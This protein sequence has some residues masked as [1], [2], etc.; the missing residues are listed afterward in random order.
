MRLTKLELH[1]F[2][3]FAD[4]TTLAFEAGVTAIVGP[5]GCGK[6][7]VSDAVRWVL[8]EQ[9][10][11]LLRGA[12]MDEVIFQGSSA[13]RPVSMA[14]VSLHFDNDDGM[15]PVAYREV[16]VTRR[17]SRSGESEYLLN[18][19]PC[20]LR[21]IHDL[22]RGTGLGADAG[23]VI[24]SRMIDALLSDRPDDR[25]ELFEEAAGIGLYRDRRRTTERRLEETSIDLARLDDLVAEVQT[26]V[27][28]LARQRR[29]AERYSE[30]TARRFAVDVTLGMRELE[31]A[32]VEVAGLDRAADELRRRLPESEI[33]AGTAE[34]QRDAA[35]RDRA[36][37]EGM[38]TDLARLV[39][40]QHQQV[41]A[42]QGELAVADERQR[43]ALARRQRAEDERR[44]GEMTGGRILAEREAAA[45]ERRETE[46]VVTAASQTLADRVG[47]ED[48]AR[49][50]LAAARHGAD[51][52]DQLVREL[53]DA[54]AHLE[55]ERASAER[56]HGEILDRVDVLAAERAV[57]ADR[58]AS[59]ERDVRQAVE[60]QAIADHAFQ[61]ASA[62]SAALRAEA[63]AARES[64]ADA[65]R[66][67]ARAEASLA[68][69]EGK[70]SALERLERDRV[71]LAP[72]AARLLAVR[73][74][75]GDGA[76]LG[77]L[78]DFLTTGA[79]DATVVERYLG[80]TVHAVVV[81][82]HA[83]ATAVRAW[84]AVED[85]G[86][87]CLLPLDAV[88]QLGQGRRP[89]TDL[90]DTSLSAGRASG[91][92]LADRVT[93]APT[94]RDWV[95]TLLGGVRDLGDGAAFEDAQGAMWLPGT[96]SGQ[97]PLRRRAELS[98]LRTARTAGASAREA[99]A[100]AT[101]KAHLALADAQARSAAAD[102]AAADA[103]QR[104]RRSREFQAECERQLDRVRRDIKQAEEFWAQLSSRGSSLA[105][106]VAALADQ[107]AT[108]E[109][110][111]AEELSMAARARGALEHAERVQDGTRE[112]RSAAQVEVAQAEARAQVARDRERRLAEEHAAATGRVDALSTEL[113]SLS[114]A[115]GELAQQMAA[116]RVDLIGRRAALV[117]AETKLA[118]AEAAVR[119]ADTRLMAADQA[120]DTARHEGAGLAA[121]L[122]RVE[123]RRS[124]LTGRQLAIRE[125][126]EAEWKRPWETLAAS[127]TPIDIESEVLRTEA[128]DLQEQITAL[129][130]VNA[131][132]VEEHDEE[133]KRLE[134]LTTQRADLAAGRASLQQAIREIDSTARDLFLGTFTLVR[135]NFRRIFMTLFGG[136][137]CDL[138]LENPDAPLECDIEIHASPRGKR[139]QRIHL[140]SSG[141]RA[142]VALSL[143]FGIFL[144]KPSPF[145]LL[146]EVD[147]PLDDQNI[148]R[149]VR[150]LNE[151][152]TRTQFIIITHNPRT[153]TE[154]ADAVY[155]V[156]MQEP[157]ISSVVSV[158]LERSDVARIQTGDETAAEPALQEA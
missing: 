137:E 76:V 52:R 109:A 72:A 106:R 134:F 115:D 138:R 54:V 8:G 56:E 58:E 60:E 136:G 19:A 144:T 112:A 44:A 4:S 55:I 17:L 36:T 111:L 70:V 122:H 45:L 156:T 57:L 77:P 102:G 78:S 82:D 145:C 107:R 13:R 35:H 46:A 67:F 98:A 31:T 83:A 117:E 65:Y 3:S 64:E 80:A 129:G 42:L 135:D 105:A 142:L 61:V 39:A 132:A 124:D 140:L 26:Q 2:K 53:R 73:S 21:D 87:L 48:T 20:R 92:S 40:S 47:H 147:A 121:E 91:P 104:A 84:H 85:P 75:F 66:T 151:F 118:D 10:A 110:Q 16:V 88:T 24:E 149:F 14:E 128:T 93:P 133:L 33:A 38:R 123:L 89:A 15:L 146:D 114:T 108:S 119:D 81:R 127:C 37:A 153:T 25:R 43:N 99:A 157:G 90:G 130:P 63:T 95:Q 41:A 32:Q 71:G 139:T 23:V 126:L 74:R 27:R 148:G 50:S 18:R 9:R 101:S 141:E 49:L 30:L 68:E 94:V 154:A 51:A 150:M 97:G 155:G 125:K 34:M 96:Q 158:R 28:S 120:L 6:S 59:S 62:H 11:R 5:N 12:K 1:G 29:R 152:K 100:D 7:N 143:L 79:V 86:P 131:L 116:W 69:V 103:D 113:Q 22:M